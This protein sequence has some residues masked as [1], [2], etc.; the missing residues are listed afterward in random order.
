MAFHTAPVFFVEE[1]RRIG[2]RAVHAIVPVKERLD[3]EPHA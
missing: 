3:G 2:R 1:P